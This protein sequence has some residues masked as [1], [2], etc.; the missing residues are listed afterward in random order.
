MLAIRLGLWLLPFR[1][2]L[3]LLERV[4]K[5]PG[6]RACTD[7]EA[8]W[9][10]RVVSAVSRGLPQATCLT[11]ALALQAM[12]QRRNWPATLRLGV[13]RDGNGR[14]IAHAWVE[15]EG[16]VLIGGAELERYAVMPTL[17]ASR[18]GGEPSPLASR[19]VRQ[20]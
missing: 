1:T 4:I 18:P 7:G 6:A 20:R 5:L 3:G 12:L 2:V 11:Q 10:S 17:G 14:F 15:C 19:S 8:E 16:Q 9:L 13:A